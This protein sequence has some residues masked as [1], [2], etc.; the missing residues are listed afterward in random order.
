MRGQY[1]VSRINIGACALN[2]PTG[3]CPRICFIAF[4][5]FVPSL[6]KVEGERK[7]LV[8]PRRG[9]NPRVKADRILA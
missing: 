8:A 3:Y 4:A 2:L 6:P 1:S 7:A 9:R 5:W